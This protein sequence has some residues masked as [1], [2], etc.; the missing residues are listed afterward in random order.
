MF[1]KRIVDIISCNKIILNYL[2]IFIN[3]NGYEELCE[4]IFIKNL[5]NII[6][7]IRY[8]PNNCDKEI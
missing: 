6:N 2:D 5:K 3:K 7:S 8:L 1:N 4:I